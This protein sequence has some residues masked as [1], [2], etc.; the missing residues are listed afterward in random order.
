MTLLES[1]A[2][3]INLAEGYGLDMKDQMPESRP[4]AGV[5]QLGSKLHYLID[6][7]L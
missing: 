3:F 4:Q 6:E 2:G 1:N 5:V 7:E